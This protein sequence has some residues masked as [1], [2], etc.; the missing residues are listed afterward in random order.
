MMMSDKPSGFP[1]CFGLVSLA[2]SFLFYIR[3]LALGCVGQK[4]FNLFPLNSVPWLLQAP[5]SSGR[6]VVGALGNCVLS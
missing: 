3:S 6:Q 4:T 2:H 1:L 5:N